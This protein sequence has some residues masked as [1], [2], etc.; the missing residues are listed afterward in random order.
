MIVWS[1]GLGK[2]RLP[3]ELKDASLRRESD[4]L[5]M[6]GIIEPVYWNYR[7]R[8]SP[9]DLLAFLKLLTHT[10]TIGFLAERQ[11]IL[12]PFVG[13]LI[14]VLPRLVFNVLAEKTVGRFRR[15]EAK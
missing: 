3:L 6:E 14:A 7:I 15:K 9:D 11:G 1:K 2:Q 13:K 8:L 5:A 10:K 12:L 4:R